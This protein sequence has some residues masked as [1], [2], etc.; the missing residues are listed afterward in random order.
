LGKARLKKVTADALLFSNFGLD[1][2]SFSVISYLNI[3]LLMGLF[4]NPMVRRDHDFE[5]QVLLVKQS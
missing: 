4:Q 2:L 3:T 5:R 1:K